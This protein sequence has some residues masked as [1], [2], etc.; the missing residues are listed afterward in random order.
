MVPGL[1]SMLVPTSTASDF[2]G[3]GELHIC[4]PWIWTV[5]VQASSFFSSN[6]DKWLEGHIEGIAAGL[7]SATNSSVILQQ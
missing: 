7:V 2:A 3:N 1:S 5:P 4:F 6:S